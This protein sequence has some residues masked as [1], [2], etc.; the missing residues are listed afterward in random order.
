MAQSKT[1]RHKCRPACTEESCFFY[2]HVFSFPTTL[3]LPAREQDGQL[4]CGDRSSLP[5]SANHDCTQCRVPLTCWRAKE[6]PPANGGRSHSSALVPLWGV[7]R[8]GEPYRAS[9]MWPGLQSEWLFPTRPNSY[10]PTAPSSE[11]TVN[12]PYRITP[13]SFSNQARYHTSVGT[14]TQ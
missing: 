5:R 3:H 1:F 4:H 12:L 7:S 2:S 9:P 8:L 10:A 11:W 6:M 13:S 14:G